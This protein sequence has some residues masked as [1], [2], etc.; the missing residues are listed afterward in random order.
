M[1]TQEFETRFEN[2]LVD[3][4]RGKRLIPNSAVWDIEDKG[5]PYPGLEPYGKERRS[6]L[7]FCPLFLAK[8]KPVVTSWRRRLTAS[9]KSSQ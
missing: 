4:L 2:L 3:Q 8:Q 6:V 1:M 5:S 7:L 9:S